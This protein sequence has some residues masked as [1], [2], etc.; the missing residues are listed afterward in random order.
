LSDS[1]SAI[2][3]ERMIDSKREHMNDVATV[4]MMTNGRTYRG[5]W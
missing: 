5:I 2:V 3:V 1:I 4:R